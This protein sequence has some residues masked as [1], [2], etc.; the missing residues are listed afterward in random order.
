[1]RGP[2]GLHLVVSGLGNI[3]VL[4]KALGT[5]LWPSH[6]GVPDIEGW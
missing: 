2:G 4:G 1:M 6:L 5:V 3:E